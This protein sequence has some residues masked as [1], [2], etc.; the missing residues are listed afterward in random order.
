MLATLTVPML[1]MRA[2]VFPSKRR[3]LFDKHILRSVPYDLFLFGPF[4]GFMGMYIPFYYISA[5]SV[6]HNIAN[7]DVSFYLLVIL[8]ASSV[9]GRVVPNFFADRT[10]PLNVIGP[11]C[12]FCALVAFC[13][14]SVHSLGQIV[15]FCIFYGFFSGTFVSMTGPALATLSNDMSLV[16]THMGMNF[17]FGAFGLLIGN[18]VAGK[19][20]DKGWVAP[21]M[22]CGTANVLAALFCLAARF[23][24]VGWKLKVKV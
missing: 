1:V 5:Y 11:F 19:L 12:A 2:K 14:P 10:G 6:A 8:N 7:E 18:P 23:S 16:G 17:A 24:K 4:F 9:F 21:A 20:L 3:P 13:W 15:A 22:F